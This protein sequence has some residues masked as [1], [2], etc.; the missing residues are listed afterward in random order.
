VVELLY[1]IRL[2][3]GCTHNQAARSTFIGTQ[4]A[5][6]HSLKN[7]IR[8][9]WR[10][11]CWC[12]F[13]KVAFNVVAVVLIFILAG[14]AVALPSSHF[15]NCL[16]LLTVL[17]IVLAV[18][19]YW[20]LTVALGVSQ[21]ALARYLGW[22]S[23]ND[24][25]WEKTGRLARAAIALVVIAEVLAILVNNANFSARTTYELVRHACAEGGR[26]ENKLHSQVCEGKMPLADAQ[27]CI[28][29]N[30]A[31]CWNKYVAP[32]YGAAPTGPVPFV[33]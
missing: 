31:E 10:T 3:Y 17:S 2:G 27:K 11:I 25:F 6:M 19:S 5:A 15:Q 9:I 16:P 26:P 8:F 7:S 20:P 30:W 13:F 1:P 28:L 23:M 18:I 32:G 29:S 4:Q 33:P 12:I 14:S 21:V 24:L 22:R